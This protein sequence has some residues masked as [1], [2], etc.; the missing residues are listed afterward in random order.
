MN[1]NR[2]SKMTRI[3]GASGGAQFNIDIAEDISYE[4]NPSDFSANKNDDFTNV[5]SGKKNSIGKE[6]SER[7][8]DV[9][10]DFPE[11]RIFKVDNI[12][13]ILEEGK[14]TALKS[15]NMKIK[16]MGLKP[17]VLSASGLPSVDVT[18]LNILAGDPVNCKFG[19][20]Y[21]HFK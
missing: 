10:D 8:I 21:T 5:Y 7:N 20:A 17:P 1:E 14:D 2:K 3:G 18:S 9:M 15:K 6:Q 11:E 19:T 13:G 4:V 16:G 12:R